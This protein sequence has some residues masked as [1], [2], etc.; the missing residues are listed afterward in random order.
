MTRAVVGWLLC[1]CPA[2]PVAQQPPRHDGD[3]IRRLDTF[4]EHEVA[5]IPLCNASAS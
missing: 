4:V 3:L 1:V 5:A 2:L